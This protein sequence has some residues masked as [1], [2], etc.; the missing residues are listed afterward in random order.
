MDFSKFAGRKEA[1]EKIERFKDQYTPIMLYRTTVFSHAH[2]VC[3]LLEDILDR[4][5]EVHPKFDVSFA[6]A[7][8]LVHDDVEIE[9]GDVQL[10]QKEAMDAAARDA[11]AE[12]EHVAIDVLANRWPH[13]VNAHAYEELL[14]V[15]KKKERVEARVVSYC[16]KLD[17]LGESL[18]ELFAGNVPF[19]RPAQNYIT[20]RVP[21]VVS[22]FAEVAALFSEN[23]PLLKHVQ[24]PDLAHIANYGKPHTAESLRIPTDIPFYERWKAVTIAH[25]GLGPLVEQK[26][27]L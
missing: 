27:Y 5:I 19:I 2:R 20:K 23:H 15:A 18:H 22:D 7:L 1:L 12:K 24:L 4:V 16:D 3:W 11:L 8:A 21:K 26:E 17:A 25:A 9:T 6:K 13:F 14:V 10:Y